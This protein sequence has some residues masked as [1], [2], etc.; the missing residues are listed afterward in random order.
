MSAI[1]SLM[2][3]C[4]RQGIRSMEVSHVE[5]ARNAKKNI[6]IL[7][8]NEVRR[9]IESVRGTSIVAVRDRAI[10]ELLAYS[11]IRVSE[12]TQ[13]NLD[14]LNFDTYEFRVRG[15]GGKYRTC[16]FTPS[17]AHQIKHWLNVRTDCFPAL[18]I[19][20]SYCFRD[21]VNAN[22]RGRLSN[23]SVEKIVRHYT[24]RAGINKHVTPHIF[25]H[26]WSTLLLQN[27][28]DIRSLQEM[29]G[30][31]SL[32]TTQVY[33]HVSPQHLKKSYN[34]YVPTFQNPQQ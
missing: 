8:P 27:G 13:L 3:F 2:N 10:L 34:Q 17:A 33:L 9:I 31:S 29:L 21:G 7:T 32:N 30:H 26:T 6:R 24:E 1:R 14:D 28:C 20:L 19:S 12:L 25:R 16:F 11:G 22:D 15:K 18:F 23:T 5:L 4:K